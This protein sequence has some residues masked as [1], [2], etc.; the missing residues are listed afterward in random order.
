LDNSLW[1]DSEGKT[2]LALETDRNY[3]FTLFF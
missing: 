3:F 2:L 1:T